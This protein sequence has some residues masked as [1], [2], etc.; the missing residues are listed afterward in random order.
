MLVRVGVVLGALWWPGRLEG[1]V[2][3]LGGRILGLF[4]SYFG[5]VE[6]WRAE[7]FGDVCTLG[8]VLG[9]FWLPGG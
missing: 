6:G 3:F 2:F 4:C 1:S 9:T 8:F 5:G 7:I